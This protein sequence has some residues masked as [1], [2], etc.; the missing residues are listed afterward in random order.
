[1][2]VWKYV[3]TFQISSTKKQVLYII[4][5]QNDIYL[6]ITLI[7]SFVTNFVH[8]IQLNTFEI[9]ENLY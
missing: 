6:Y 5:K 8:T 4:H 7:A 1:M 9:D 3:I 2:T